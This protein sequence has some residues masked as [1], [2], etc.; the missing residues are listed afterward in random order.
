LS[1]ILQRKSFSI[2]VLMAAVFLTIDTVVPEYVGYETLVLAFAACVLLVCS[3]LIDT[4]K[5]GLICGLTVLVAQNAGAFAK[6]AIRDGP[7]IAAATGPYPLFL[8]SSYVIV[9]LLGG[10][11]GGRLREDHRETTKLP[12]IKRRV[13]R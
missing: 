8:T 1:Q 12:G 11:L 4:P 10:Y 2:G 9:G 6:V 13:A 5:E 3:A 7:A